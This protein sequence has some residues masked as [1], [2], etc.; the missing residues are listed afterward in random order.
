MG[1]TE[2][3]VPHSSRDGS[4]GLRHLCQACSPGSTRVSPPEL[5]FHTVPP[6]SGGK[7]RLPEKLVGG[8]QP[9]GGHEVRQGTAGPLNAAY[10]SS[11]LA[12]AH[13]ARPWGPGLQNRGI[14]YSGL[15][16]GQMGASP[17]D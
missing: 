2:E 14:S 4:M 10:V 16:R 13:Q 8:C 15:T 7:H 17:Q 12:K 11:L 3:L 9:V 6:S 5:G 1:D